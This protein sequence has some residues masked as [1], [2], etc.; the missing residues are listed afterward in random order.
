VTVTR[1]ESTVA[2]GRLDRRGSID[3]QH[4]TD[5]MAV[6]RLTG[7]VVKYP[8]RFALIAYVFLIAAG[9]VA[10]TLP[11]CQGNPEKP[12]TA[13]D[14]TFMSTSAV[15]V[16]GLA[17][18]SVGNDL[19]FAGQAVLLALVQLGG[20][21]IIT[22][23]TLATFGVIRGGGMRRQLAVTES[24]GSR[25]SDDPLWVVRIVILT[26]LGIEA[27]GFVALF[28][29]NLGDMPPLDAAWHALFHSVSAFCNAGFGLS[30]QSLIAYRADVVVNLT[31]CTL[32]IVGGIGFPVLLEVARN[33]LSRKHRQPQTLSLH[34]RLVLLGT[35]GL[36]LIGTGAFLFLEHNN[37]LE[38]TPWG[39]RV[40]VAFFHSTTCRTAGFNTVE[41]GRLTDAMLFVSI[42]LMMIG[43]CP[44]STGG[45]FKVSAM[46]VL[47]VLSWNR[48]RGYRNPQFARRTISEDIIDRSVASV[49]LYILVAVVALTAMLAIEEADRPHVDSRGG[50]LE[51]LFEVVSALGTVGLSTGI[52]TQLSDAGRILLILL[53]FIGRLG[54]ISIFVAVSQSQRD[55]RIEYA[56]EDVL[57]G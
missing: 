9:A 31:M 17:V 22:V 34:S 54:P 19:S 28:V 43:A 4:S 12:L 36:L 39:E 11:V 38:G 6:L 41:I 29:R 47:G 37:T 8:A 32:I 5:F 21:G 49:L 18:R 42:L 26:T 46:M 1:R 48:L 13:L 57:I 30:D 33:R 16:T 25:P 15:C 27:A 7:T 20:I 44:C 14:A 52:T 3:P 35:A 24:L 53:M 40:L 51:A 55:S 23:T 50:S 45:G 2:A 10:L 56:K